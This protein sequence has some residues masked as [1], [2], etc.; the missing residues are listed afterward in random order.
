MNWHLMLTARQVAHLLVVCG[1]GDGECRGQVIQ[2]RKPRPMLAEC[3][4]TDVRTDVREV[5][6]AGRG[7]RWRA[8]RWKSRDEVGDGSG[9]RRAE[10]VTQVLPDGGC[11]LT[12]GRMD[13]A[14]HGAELVWRRQGFHRVWA[15]DVGSERAGFSGAA[16]QSAPYPRVRIERVGSSHQTGFESQPLKRPVRTV[17]SRIVSVLGA[18]CCRSRCPRSLTGWRSLRVIRICGE[19]YRPPQNWSHLRGASLLSHRPTGY[20]TPKAGSAGPGDRGALHG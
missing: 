5:C 15:R 6:E 20:R 19:M 18:E 13:L 4:L 2:E 11:E 7:G 12:G 16:R 8:L 9:R 10:R 1:V 14:G 3:Q 17:A